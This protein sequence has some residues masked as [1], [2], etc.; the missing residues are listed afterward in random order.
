MCRPLQGLW[1]QHGI[2]LGNQTIPTSERNR[3]EVFEGKPSSLMSVLKANDLAASGSFPSVHPPI[4]WLRRRRE[5]R[6]V[7]A[8]AALRGHAH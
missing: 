3:S 8:R 5:G 2:V 1:D 7:L 4:S 6:S